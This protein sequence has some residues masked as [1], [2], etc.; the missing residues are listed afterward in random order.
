MTEQE[1]FLRQ[2]LRCEADL[3]AL[4]GAVVGDVHVRED[5]YQEIA[6]TLWQHFGRYD[7]SRPFQPW[8]RGVAAKKLLERFSGDR[9][10][11][12]V[13]SPDAIL[14]L[15]EAAD[16]SESR[17]APG[18]EA[19]EHCLG[20]LPEKSRRLLNLRYSQAQPL[21]AIAAEFEVEGTRA[22]RVLDDA[23]LRVVGNRPA[24]IELA[25]G[26]RAELAVSTAAVIRR[27]DNRSGQVLELFEGGGRFRVPRQADRSFRVETCSGSV[28]TL[29]TDFEVNLW[30]TEGKGDQDMSFRSM[31]V[32]AVAVVTGMVHVE[33]PGQALVLSAGSQ[34]VFGAEPEKQKDPGNWLPSGDMLGF[35]GKGGEPFALE[36]SVPGVVGALELTV[37]AEAE[38]WS[39]RSRD[40]P[41]RKGSRRRGAGQAQPQRDPS[42]ERRGSKAGRRSSG[43]T[44]TTGRHDS[45]GRAKEARRRHQHGCR[46]SPSRGLGVRAGGTI[47]GQAR[48][49]RDE[50][51]ART[52]PS[53]HGCSHAEANRGDAQSGAEGGVRAGRSSSGGR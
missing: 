34:K 47:A 41:E 35:T 10:L 6:L 9:R 2:F 38:D 18:F 3:R 20:K 17:P 45:H 46:P 8:A 14:K 50:A 40:D 53:A 43:Q 42:P 16:R 31:F 39:G 36:R 48:R 22:T 33:V 24:V 5:V 7:P 32:L 29:G 26:T 21:A 25:G 4:V 15:V 23:P 12:L 11:P 13:L 28:T 44:P 52:G 51:L 19:L 1:E 49:A 30:S 37:R 27:P